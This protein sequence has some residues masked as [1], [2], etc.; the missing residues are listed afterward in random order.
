[1]DIF[2]NTM[3]IHDDDLMHDLYMKLDNWMQENCEIFDDNKS[4][5]QW[6]RY[7]LNEAKWR[8]TDMLRKRQKDIERYYDLPEVKDNDE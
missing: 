6:M 7:I 8:L 2:M 3:K 1:M 5:K 4:S